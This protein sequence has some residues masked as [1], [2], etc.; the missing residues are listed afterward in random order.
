MAFA[1]KAIIIWL[2]SDQH[3]VAMDNTGQDTIESARQSLSPIVVQ[4]RA[5]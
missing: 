5:L 2:E 1:F 4:R 3:A